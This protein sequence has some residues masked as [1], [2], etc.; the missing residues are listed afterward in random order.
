MTGWEY[1]EYNRDIRKRREEAIQSGY[2]ETQ[3]GAANVIKELMA[4]DQVEIA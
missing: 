3:T 2:S 4:V 1:K